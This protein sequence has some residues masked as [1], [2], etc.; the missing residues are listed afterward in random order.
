[1]RA[2]AGRPRPRAQ[3]ADRFYGLHMAPQFQGFV[4]AHAAISFG[5]ATALVV[6]LPPVGIP[7]LAGAAFVTGSRFYLGNHYPT[8]C[9]LGAALG[10]W[11][12][13]GFGLAARRLPSQESGQLARSPRQRLA[14][15]KRKA[16][17]S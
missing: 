10:V 14:A 16:P 11:L 8:D 4:S 7:A 2:A 17:A 3:M 5:T 1:M 12:G 9:L 6:T 13:L 15:G